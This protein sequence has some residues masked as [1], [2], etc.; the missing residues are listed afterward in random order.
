[1]N[2]LGH[3]IGRD[4]NIWTLKFPTTRRTEVISVDRKV[5]SYTFHPFWCS[6]HVLS[7]I[8]RPCWG[9]FTTCSRVM[10]A[11][12]NCRLQVTSTNCPPPSFK[13]HLSPIPNPPYPTSALKFHFF[14]SSIYSYL[15]YHLYIFFVLHFSLITHSFLF[16]LL[17]PACFS[18]PLT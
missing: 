18:H 17:Q 5:T 9:D 2:I 11:Y 3:L 14:S 8:P 15:Y 1:M 12:Q 4:F 6:E 13:F 10:I 16:P 7:W